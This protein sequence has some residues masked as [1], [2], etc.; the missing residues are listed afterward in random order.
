M[1]RPVLH[2]DAEEVALVLLQRRALGLGQMVQ[3]WLEEALTTLSRDRWLDLLL[4]DALGV[5]IQRTRRIILRWWLVEACLRQPLAN[6]YLVRRLRQRV[7]RN[8]S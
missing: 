4:H 3:R 2:K 8:C 5:V 6:T 7:Q 1:H